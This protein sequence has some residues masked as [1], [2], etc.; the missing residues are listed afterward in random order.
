MAETSLKLTK[1]DQVLVNALMSLVLPIVVRHAEQEMHLDV[2]HRV[3]PRVNREHHY[4][5]PLADWSEVMLASRSGRGS[6]WHRAIFEIN[7]ALAALTTWRLGLLMDDLR[8][9]KQEK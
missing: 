6:D 8:A 3:L 4:I 5:L 7:R 1:Y 9:E 2:I